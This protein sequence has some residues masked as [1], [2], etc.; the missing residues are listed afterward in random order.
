MG[1][2]TKRQPVKLICGFIFKDP[3]ILRKAQNLLSRYFGKIDFVSQVIPFI[4]TVYYQEELGKDL[5]RR[6]VSFKELILPQRL[7][8]I[9][10]L[11]NKIETKLSLEG[12]RRI[13]IDPGYLDLSKV[14]LAST[15]DYTHRIYLNGGIYAEVT[16]F[17]QRRTFKSWEWTYPD[18]RSQEYIAVFNQIRE[19]Y[20]TQLK[21]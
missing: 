9:K 6:F 20:K 18:Y 2:I 3:C 12:C 21:K 15:K 5:Q 8:K 4:H 17:Y 7:P 13:N 19:I 11:T 16:L 14:I 10:I 1:I